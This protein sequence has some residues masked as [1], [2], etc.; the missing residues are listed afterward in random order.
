MS[1]SEALLD[2]E[3]HDFDTE[4][5]FQYRPLS[6]AAIASVVFGLVSSRPFLAGNNSLQA[7]LM[8]CPIPVVGLICGIVALK[9]FREIPDQF[10]GHNMAIA[11]T[12][13]SLLGLVGGLS[14]AG[15]IHATEVPPGYERMS[16]ANMR[17][18]KVELK[19]NESIPRDVQALDSEKIFIKGYIRPGTHV[20]KGGT[21]VRH[22]VSR[23]LLVRDSNECCFGDISTVKYYDKILVHLTDNLKTDY[24]GGMFRVGGK[25]KVVPANPQAGHPD[26]TY[27]LEAD[28]VQ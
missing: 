23:F 24:S 13:M 16:F 21:P 26:P 22:N 18:D 11:G 1:A 12:V 27:F 28:Y 6:T 9:K 2:S 20:S 4:D 17:P 10:S 7:C 14:Y 15:Y 19:G 5:D 25:L 3:P 8:L